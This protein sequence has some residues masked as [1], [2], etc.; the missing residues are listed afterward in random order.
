MVS[1]SNWVS[2]GLLG[3]YLEQKQW[4]FL[5]LP[6]RARTT[7]LGYL[8]RLLRRGLWSDW[9]RGCSQFCFQ[10]VKY[11]KL[12]V[13]SFTIYNGQVPCQFEFINKPDEESYCKQ[14]LNASPSRGFLLPGEASLLTFLLTLPC[15]CSF[16]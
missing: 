6:E 10:D 2:F 15:I 16:S 12:Q 5:F 14:W 3:K 8:G 11:M 13:Q 9:S 4:S 7:Q 1:R